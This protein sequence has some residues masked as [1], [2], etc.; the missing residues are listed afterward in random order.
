MWYMINASDH[1]QDSRPK[2][3]LE[4]FDTSASQGILRMQFTTPPHVEAASESRQGGSEPLKARSE[5]HECL[6]LRDFW[7]IENEPRKASRDTQG[8]ESIKDAHSSADTTLTTSHGQEPFETYKKKD[9]PTVY[10]YLLPQA[11]ER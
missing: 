2:K 1:F 10:H 7:L 3:R 8:V 4:V 6:A 5:P 9:T 11:R